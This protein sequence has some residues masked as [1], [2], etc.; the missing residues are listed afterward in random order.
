MIP[1][2]IAA[3]SATCSERTTIKATALFG[4]LLIK[5][6]GI[7]TRACNRY[8]PNAAISA[9]RVVRLAFMRNACT[10]IAISRIPSKATT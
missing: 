2:Q 5:I 6:T 8:G 7:P 9:L 1:H 3:A 10:I 4:S